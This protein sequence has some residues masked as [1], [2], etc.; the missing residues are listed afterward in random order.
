MVD[1][2]IGLD[3]AWLASR[4]IVDKITIVTGDSDFIP[5]MKFARKEGI[6]VTLC[7][8][9]KIRPEMKE[10]ADEYKMLKI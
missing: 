9:P 1:V 8:L 10:H 4:K 3:I 5:A 7:S 6:H 2:K